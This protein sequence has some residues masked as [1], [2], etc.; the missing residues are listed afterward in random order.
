MSALQ[1]PCTL[2]KSQKR[3]DDYTASDMRCGDLS[4][5]T[6]K[7]HF[8]LTEVSAK[9]DPYTLTEI[10]PFRQPQSM[11][12]GSRGAGKKL[13]R[14]QC[15]RILFDEFR[16][17][18]RPFAV[19]G[20]YKHLIEQMITHMQNCN[21]MPFRS[22]HLNAALEKRILND[23]A[24]DS[25]LSR[26]K[27]ALTKFTD[28]NN[29]YYP[30]NKKDEFDTLIRTSYLP[31]FAKFQDS[32]NGMGITVHDTY[33]THI[34]IK[35]LHIQK[36]EYR[37][38]VHYRVQDHFGL[39]NEDILKFKFYQFRFFRIW[40]VLQRYNQLAFKPFMTNMEATLEIIGNRND[41][42]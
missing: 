29:G 21:G 10:T 5:T 23:K 2:F 27:I 20:P 7:R 24:K 14:E 16:Q 32:F 28:W 1:L 41:K 33:A 17:L 6:L 40:F 25:S 19:Y 22:L 38:I 37:A 26:I 11:F 9:V 36:D 31:K 8:N 15:A 3:M 34:T 42:I 35:S 18:S 39:D 12:Y 30:V 13:S 4:E